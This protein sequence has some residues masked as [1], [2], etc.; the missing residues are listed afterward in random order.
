M[1]KPRDGFST[2]SRLGSQILKQTLFPMVF[3]QS[4]ILAILDAESVFPCFI[5]E[6]DKI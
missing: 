4:N 2:I 6:G 5:T 1:G 3:A